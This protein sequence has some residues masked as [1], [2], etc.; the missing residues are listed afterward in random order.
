MTFA[1]ALTHRPFRMSRRPAPAV[2]SLVAVTDRRS[3][4]SDVFTQNTK[5]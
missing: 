1:E 2:D 5:C 3:L 4:D